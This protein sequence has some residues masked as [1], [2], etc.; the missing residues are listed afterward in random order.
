MNGPSWF[1]SDFVNSMF[2][3]SESIAVQE[4]NMQH[5]VERKMISY[6]LTSLIA[7]L[8]SKLRVA[9]QTGGMRLED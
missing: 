7:P 8:S 1:C 5:L 6:S 3:F 9:V 2:P 4:R